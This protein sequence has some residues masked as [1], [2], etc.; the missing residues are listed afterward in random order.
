[1]VRAYSLA[2]VVFYITLYG[3]FPLKVI[4][5]EIMHISI[6]EYHSPLGVLIIGSY[7]DALCLCDWKYRKARLQIDQRIQ[8]SLNTTYKESTSA[9]IDTT[10]DQLAAYFKGQLQDI[11]V[12][13]RMVGT[14]FQQKIWQALC[15]VPYGTTISYSKLASNASSDAIRAVA[16]ANGANA[17]SIIIPCHRVIGSNGSLTGYAGGLSAKKKLLEIEGFGAHQL[18]LFG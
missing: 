3:I 17:M 12:P 8:Q 5:L 9:I 15:E 16:A 6:K 2:F 1:M 7:E 4:L 14:P 10:I 18:G 11:Q 13:V